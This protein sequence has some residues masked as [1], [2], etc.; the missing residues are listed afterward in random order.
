MNMFDF[1]GNP[2]KRPVILDPLSGRI[3]RR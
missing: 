1:D 2:D 3:V